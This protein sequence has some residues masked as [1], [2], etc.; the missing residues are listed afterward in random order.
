MSNTEKI[1]NCLKI[2][3]TVKRNSFKRKVVYKKCLE[4]KKDA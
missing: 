2:F 1:S 3:L 4:I